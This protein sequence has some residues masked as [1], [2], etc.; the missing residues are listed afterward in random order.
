MIALGG[1]PGIR[2]YEIGCRNSL[3]PQ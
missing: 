3:C 1:L 2:N